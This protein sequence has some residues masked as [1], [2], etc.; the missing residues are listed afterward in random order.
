M[1]KRSRDEWSQQRCLTLT[2]A[3]IYKQQSYLEKYLGAEKDA[4]LRFM[5][6]THAH[7][8][9]R[10][11]THTHKVGSFKNR[12]LNLNYALWRMELVI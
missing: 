3:K 11:H 5:T 8:R 4:T 7:T 9:G 2:L 1:G 12:R 10:A 6:R